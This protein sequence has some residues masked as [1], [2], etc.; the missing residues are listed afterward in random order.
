MW[1]NRRRVR[2]PRAMERMTRRHP[3][4]A[5]RRPPRRG[6]GRRALALARGR[7][8]VASSPLGP[9]PAGFRRLGGRPRPPALLRPPPPARARLEHATP[10]RSA[11]GS[12]RAARPCSRC[13]PDSSG[14][15]EIVGA[16]YC[17]LADRIAAHVYYGGQGSLVSVF[18]MSGPARI[19]DGWSGEVGG[20]QVRLSA[21]PA[22]RS[23]SWARVEPTS[24]APPARSCDARPDP[25]AARRLTGPRPKLL[26][27][28]LPVGL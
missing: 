14:H 23:R 5:T 1:E 25:A 16:R 13:P 24:R 11:T 2:R 22:A 7:A 27:F 6:R 15:V 8:L 26:T 19:G 20:L 3:R 21:R 18:V 10:P 9:W 4:P 17:P 12:S 28:L